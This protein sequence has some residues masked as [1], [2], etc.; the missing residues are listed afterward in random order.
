M[1]FKKYKSSFRDDVSHF[2][3]AFMEEEAGGKLSAKSELSRELSLV[4]TRGFPLLCHNFLSTKSRA[5]WR[6]YIHTQTFVAAATMQKIHET[7]EIYDCGTPLVLLHV[8][9]SGYKNLG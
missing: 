6:I 5:A 8:D 1:L 4:H 3:G 9:T 7:L 2:I